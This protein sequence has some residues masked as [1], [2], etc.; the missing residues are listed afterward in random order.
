MTGTLKMLAA[1]ARPITL[2]KSNCRSMDMTPK[3]ICGWWSMKMT[4][5]FCGVSRPWT[6]FA[7]A[8]VF[9]MRVPPSLQGGED[10]ERLKGI[11]RRSGRR[12]DRNR[13]D[14]GVYLSI[15]AV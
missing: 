2:L 9:A 14:C 8:G 13:V 10:A 11:I 4:V 7:G 6:R 3:V 15:E 1:L 5:Q 12:D